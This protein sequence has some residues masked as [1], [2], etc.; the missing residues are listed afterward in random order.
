VISNDGHDGNTYSDPIEN[1]LA[2]RSVDACSVK[3]PASQ[4]SQ[5]SSFIH[6]KDCLPI[7][8]SP[9]VPIPLGAVEEGATILRL[10]QR[11]SWTNWQYNLN[12]SDKRIE[13]LTV[14]HLNPSSAN[15]HSP[16][17]STTR[18]G[19]K[20]RSPELPLDRIDGPPE[21]SKHLASNDLLGTCNSPISY[22][23]MGSGF[24]QGLIIC[25]SSAYLS[26][27]A[28]GNFKDLGES[29]YSVM[30]TQ[31][32]ASVLHN[33]FPPNSIGDLDNISL[34][35]D[36]DIKMEFSLD[37]VDSVDVDDAGFDS[38]AMKVD[39]IKN[40]SRLH[41]SFEK[42]SLMETHSNSLDREHEPAPNAAPQAL[43]SCSSPMQKRD[44]IETAN[45]AGTK[46][47]RSKRRTASSFSSSLDFSDSQMHYVKKICKSDCSSGSMQHL[48]SIPVAS[49]DRTAIIPPDDAQGDL[50]ALQDLMT[51]ESSENRSTSPLILQVDSGPNQEIE[52]VDSTAIINQIRS[53][54]THRQVN[55]VRSS[56]EGETPALINSRSRKRRLTG[57]TKRERDIC[58]KLKKSKTVDIRTELEITKPQR[59]TR[60]CASYSMQA[61]INE[62][63]DALP[64]RRKQSQSMSSVIVSNPPPI[65]EL[66]QSGDLVWA[67]W[68]D[69]KYF[70]PG[71]IRSAS[72]TE[73]GVF[74]V[75]FLDGDYQMCSIASLRPYNMRKGQSVYAYTSIDE[76]FAATVVEIADCVED[77]YFVQFSKDKSRKY[78]QFDRV[79][80]SL[81]QMKSLDLRRPS[82]NSKPLTGE[83]DSASPP[84]ENFINDPDAKPKKDSKLRKERSFSIEKSSE[85]VQASPLASC[86]KQPLK[87]VNSL[88]ISFPKRRSTLKLIFSD[89]EFIVTVIKGDD[90]LADVPGE[91]LS[92]VANCGMFKSYF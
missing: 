34:K 48:D 10:C 86:E 52:V 22:F 46:E 75:K 56:D 45:K 17:S 87:D 69:D 53:S 76:M 4:L 68:P 49:S 35:E 90:L 54:A 31:L 73:T 66:Y 50:G 65:P 6:G 70:Y 39:E 28:A 8:L 36:D 25:Y 42:D 23:K 15:D 2:V 1:L 29:F 43:A 63:D 83:I 38:N 41:S 21:N 33:P 72:K 55:L 12:Y 27:R 32:G 37:E 74:R 5:D 62:G 57:T 71:K 61:L 40:P 9:V 11:S 89:L 82:A 20:S 14:D 47:T 7:C 64:P 13:S 44:A 84:Q 3:H 51:I 30:E 88:G 24:A 91:L 78:V 59:R 81:E 77:E 58:S 19:H 67:K 92:S 79:V 80:L 26:N 60:S 18:I 16:L 85:V